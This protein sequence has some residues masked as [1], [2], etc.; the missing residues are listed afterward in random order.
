MSRW[1]RARREPWILAHQHQLDYRSR[2]PSAVCLTWRLL[3]S[4]C[5][6]SQMRD[7]LQGLSLHRMRH[8]RWSQV[9]QNIRKSMYK[10]KCSNDQRFEV[11]RVNFISIYFFDDFN[12]NFDSKEERKSDI[13]TYENANKLSS[14]D[15]YINVT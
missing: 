5:T 4:R 13:N 10:V 6:S 3:P 8:Y 2:L 11:C 9:Y 12:H 1:S 15:F 14:T 7:W